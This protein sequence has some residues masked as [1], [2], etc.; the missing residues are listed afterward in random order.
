MKVEL[1]RAKGPVIKYLRKR[2]NNSYVDLEIDVNEA[3]AKKYAFTGREKFDKMAEKN[4]MLE[5]LRKT[6][7]LDIK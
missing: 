7:D 3:V 2:L 5:K 6:F 4:P 1:E